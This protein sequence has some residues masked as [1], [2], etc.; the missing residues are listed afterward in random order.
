MYVCLSVCMSVCLSVCL[1]V[2]LSIRPSV[3]L[4]VCLSVS[5]ITHSLLRGSLGL[6]HQLL[7][8]FP[9]LGAGDQD[10]LIQPQEVCH[11]YQR[12]TTIMIERK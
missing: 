8:Q 3:C 9:I 6:S 11:R 1:P 10:I 12:H 2:C 5:L 7:D 4:C